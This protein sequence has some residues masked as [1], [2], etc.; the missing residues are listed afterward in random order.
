MVPLAVAVVA[1]GAA[2]GPATAVAEA[3]N[4]ERVTSEPVHPSGPETPLGSPRMLTF[5]YA[6]DAA[7][8]PVPPEVLSRSATASLAPAAGAT[9]TSGIDANGSPG[10]PCSLMAIVV[11]PAWAAMPRPHSRLS[12][13]DAGKPIAGVA[14][15]A[16]VAA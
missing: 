6:L 8:P 3:L 12:V 16:W 10:A 7:P 11:E 1:P 14:P 15:W 2:P 5:P 13:S 9:L 4:P